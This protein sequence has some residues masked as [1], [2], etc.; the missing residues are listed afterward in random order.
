MQE[1]LIISPLIL[2]YGLQ[3]KIMRIVFCMQLNVKLFHKFQQLFWQNNWWTQWS[4]HPFHW[5]H[6]EWSLFHYDYDHPD[7]LLGCCKKPIQWT[8]QFFTKNDSLSFVNNNDIEIDLGNTQFNCKIDDQVVKIHG[9]PVINQHD[10]VVIVHEGCR[11]L[12][13]ILCF[14][15]VSNVTT[16]FDFHIGVVNNPGLYAIC[17]YVNQDVFSM[18]NLKKCY[19]EMEILWTT[20][21]IKIVTLFGVG[22]STPAIFLAIKYHVTNQ[23]QLL[24][25]SLL[26]QLCLHALE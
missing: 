24:R 12:C 4:W 17:H 19:M 25:C 14:V 9:N 13:H 20:E 23:N 2:R 11:M 10:W 21:L 1:E 26:I 3:P 8:S 7:V 6:E 15:N 22:Q 16:P 5:K 18:T